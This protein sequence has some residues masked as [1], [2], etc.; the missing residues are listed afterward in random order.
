MTRSKEE[1]VLRDF[2][3][4]K[5]NDMYNK[6]YGKESSRLIT[7]LVRAVRADERERCAK[8]AENSFV[9]SWRKQK[10]CRQ[11]I[12]AAIREGK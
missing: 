5:I 10:Q 8:V 1:R 11:D 12:A 3:I 6:N 2:V 7:A 4:P 9:A